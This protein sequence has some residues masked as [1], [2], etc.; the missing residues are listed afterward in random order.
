[1]DRR[2]RCCLEPGGPSRAPRLRPPDP[3]TATRTPVQR[4][5]RA[6]RED[7]SGWPR[8][9]PLSERFQGHTTPD[10]AAWRVAHGA[11]DS[12]DHSGSH[13]L[14]KTRLN[15]PPMISGRGTSWT[16]I[17]LAT[18]N[19]ASRWRRGTSGV[20]LRSRISRRTTAA[21]ANRVGG[22]TPANT[23]AFPR[24]MAPKAKRWRETVHDPEYGIL[25]GSLHQSLA[26]HTP[27]WV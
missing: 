26:L 2:H 3:S 14:G 19:P 18:M 23:T 13:H 16:T 15:D 27:M 5:G 20:R 8:H 1:M 9:E 4:A 7:R 25:T 22:S 17:K 11:S 21:V 24:R 10:A 12:G 6:A